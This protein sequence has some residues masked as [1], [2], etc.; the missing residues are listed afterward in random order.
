[1]AKKSYWDER[2]I[3]AAQ[4]ANRWDSGVVERILRSRK[5]PLSQEETIKNMKERGLGM[6]AKDKKAKRTL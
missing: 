1:M 6:Y 2:V 4:K 3:R 5:H